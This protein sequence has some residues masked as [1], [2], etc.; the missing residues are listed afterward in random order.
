VAIDPS[1]TQYSHILGLLLGRKWC[2]ELTAGGSS[3]VMSPIFAVGGSDL[4]EQL[5]RLIPNTSGLGTGIAMPSADEPKSDAL[6]PTG[7][8]QVVRPRASPVSRSTHDSNHHR[9]T[10]PSYWRDLQF[11]LV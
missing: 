2:G 8:C 11:A 10:G 4:D 1:G 7:R 5:E 9:S 3:S 6:S